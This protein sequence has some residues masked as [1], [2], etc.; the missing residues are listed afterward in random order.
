MMMPPHAFSITTAISVVGVVANPMFITSNP[1]P[2]S[3]A[4][5]SLLTIGP[6][7]R[8]SRPTTIV[9]DSVSVFLPIKWAYA[10]VNFTTSTGLRPSPAAPPMVPRIP[11]MDF[12]SDMIMLLY[13]FC[14]R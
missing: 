14:N 6:D 10:A 4:S 7:M 8:A 2:V 1:M 5:T 11:D 9:R 3:V 13:W 12:M